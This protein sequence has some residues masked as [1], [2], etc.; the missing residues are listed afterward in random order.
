MSS[1]DGP[2]G[3]WPQ[4]G[5]V[6]KHTAA[7]M[8]QFSRV[9]M[10]MEGSLKL[11]SVLLWSADRLQPGGEKG[12]PG[13]NRLVLVADA[14]AVPALR[15]DMNLGRHPGLGELEVI[16]DHRRCQV[17]PV[18]IGAAQ[19]GRRRLRCRDGQR[20]WKSGIEERLEVRPAV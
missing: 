7:T 5:A 9:D 13:I 10:V 12:H 16:L 1:F 6:A 20:I 4:E 2:A 3:A 17:E 11:G 14:V 8:K 18:V 15:I 19:E